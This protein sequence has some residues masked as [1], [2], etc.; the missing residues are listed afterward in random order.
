[1][2]YGIIIVDDELFVRKGL[3]EMIDWESSGFQVIDEADNGEDALDLIRKKRPHL[4]IT[5]IRMPSLD[6]I[7]LIQAV[8][9]EQLDTGFII[10]SGYNDF[11]YA[12]QAVRYGV[13]DY[14]LK[15][16]NENEILKALH[17]FRDK[18]SVQK[19]LKDRLSIHEGEQLVE[20]LI[21]GEPKNGLLEVWEKQW[22]GAKAFTYVLLEVNNVF[23]WGDRPMPVKADLK[24]GIQQ[25]IQLLCAE[26]PIVY[27]HPRAFGFIVPDLY[28]KEHDGDIR[29]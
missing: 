21:R 17:K 16:I 3:I 11:R 15:P 8:T 1:M 12:Q 13:L 2:M 20:A 14:V 25:A 9:E 7:G 10:I 26:T 23:P 19:Q 18:F 27:E 4:V 24:E 28:L 29:S 6:G 5:D 22:A